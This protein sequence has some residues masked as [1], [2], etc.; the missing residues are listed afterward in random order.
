M[1]IHFEK[2]CGKEH[3]VMKLEIHSSLPLNCYVE[4]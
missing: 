2:R 1:L 4:H 3:I